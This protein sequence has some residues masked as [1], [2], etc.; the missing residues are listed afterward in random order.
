MVYNRLTREKEPEV[1]EQADGV[2]FRT[3]D[4]VWALA[5]SS[6]RYLHTYKFALCTLT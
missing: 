6:G 3:F 1:Q 4:F 2:R 5:D